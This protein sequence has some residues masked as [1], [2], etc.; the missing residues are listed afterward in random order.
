MINTMV[1]DRVFN[2]LVW[3]GTTDPDD[4]MIALAN[5]ELGRLVVQES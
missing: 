4:G 1:G 5:E 2:V 3:F